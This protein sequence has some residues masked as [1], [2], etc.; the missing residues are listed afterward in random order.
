M[1]TLEMKTKTGS[2]TKETKK[3]G[4]LTLLAAIEQ[5]VEL[6]EGSNLSDEFYRKAGRYINYVCR[7]LSV[8]KVQAVMLALFVDNSNDYRIQLKQLASHLKCR[9]VSIMKYGKDIEDLAKRKLICCRRDR[10]SI[11]YR[12]PLE[13]IEAFSRNEAYVPAEPKNLTCDE[14]FG[15]I[16]TLL[17][18]RNSDELS[19][20]GLVHEL[21]TLFG[22]NGNLEFVQ[23]LRKYELFGDGGI[24]P[25]GVLFIYMASQLVND[26]DDKIVPH[27]FEDLFNT[28]STARRL[29]SELAH[30]VSELQEAGLVEFAN[31]D[32]FADRNAYRLTD[33]AKREMLAELDIN[34]ARKVS[35]KELVRHGDIAE[36]Q[37]FYNDTERRQVSQL[38]MLLGNE[39]YAEVRGRL[40]AA[41]MRTGF[42][43]LFYGA[44]GTGKTETALQ[45][46]R[47]TGRDIMQVNFAEIK[48]CWVGES[49][50]N[51]KEL[52]DRYRAIADKADIAP[53]L[54]FNEADAL[55]GK[56]QE[57]AERAVDKMENTIQNIILQEMEKLDGILIATTNLTQ[58]MD[59]AFERRFLYKIR[60]DKPCTDAKRAIWQAMLP[61]LNEADAVT[62]A[63]SYDF[64]G[65]Q[66]E[67]I[68]RKHTISNILYGGADGSL[69]AIT[70][71]CDEELIVKGGTK[72][73]I[74]F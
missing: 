64:S 73:K 51:V 11:T 9:N 67:N 72:R 27:Q 4:R 46:A 5:I 63:E 47:L 70:E 57:G 16:E 2:E 53:I 10:D 12:I 69:A 31:D 35:P 19:Y 17:D 20:D 38:A 6:S 30:N 18:S 55:I 29:K 43:C 61:G 22:N 33:K 23:E 49:E 58:N 24:S 25:V 52:F 40:K 28:K 60:F 71:L 36:K 50:K 66:I 74:G 54:L 32:G 13:V 7:K 59:K 26:D 8:S 65:G 21:S 34:T 68:A 39:R 62:L 48:S 15:E 56:R 3:T 42:A 45:L 44:P 1:R 37:L 41:G 14:L